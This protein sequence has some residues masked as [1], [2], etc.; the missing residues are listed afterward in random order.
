MLSATPCN[1]EIA[2]IANNWALHEVSDMGGSKNT[3]GAE[4]EYWFIHFFYEEIAMFPPFDETNLNAVISDCYS[5]NKM[6]F[7]SELLPM[8]GSLGKQIVP[9]VLNEVIVSGFYFTTRLIKQYKLN[10]GWI[11]Y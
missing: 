5:K 11:R 9:V 6:D 10:N 8:M 4:W 7:R 3:A 1:I 2:K